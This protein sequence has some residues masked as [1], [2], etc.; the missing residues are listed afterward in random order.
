MILIKWLTW[1]IRLRNNSTISKELKIETI[2]IKLVKK[3]IERDQIRIVDLEAIP[4]NSLMPLIYP[5]I[6]V[7]FYFLF[8]G[9]FNDIGDAVK[10]V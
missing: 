5:A 4:L 6:K 10:H 9:Y 1:E 7:K 8:I 2:Q 3:N